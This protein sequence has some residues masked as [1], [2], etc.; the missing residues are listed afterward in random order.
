M[1]EEINRQRHAVTM[2][3][4]IFFRINQVIYIDRQGREE[5]WFLAAELHLTTASGVTPDLTAPTYFEAPR[6]IVKKI[7][8]N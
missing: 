4:Y 8:A 5:G 7:Y 2:Y 3:L 1:K 6:I